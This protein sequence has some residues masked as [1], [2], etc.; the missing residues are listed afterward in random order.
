MT[1]RPILK[2]VAAARIAGVRTEIELLIELEDGGALFGVVG[3]S[4]CPGR[5]L[6]SFL[7]K[8]DDI[9]FADVPDDEADRALVRAFGIAPVAARGHCCELATLMIFDM[10]GEAQRV[11]SI[12]AEPPVAPGP[13][14]AS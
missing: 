7:L 4:V 12:S 8:G 3:L 14:F 2:A 10:L 6:V 9:E 11:T 5:T 13:S 1:G